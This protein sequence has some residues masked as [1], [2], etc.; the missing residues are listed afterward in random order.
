VRS[1]DLRATPGPRAE[2]AAPTDTLPE[3]MHGF[4]CDPPGLAF[5]PHRKLV[6]INACGRRMDDNP[7]GQGSAWSSRMSAVH[8]SRLCPG[9]FVTPLSAGACSYCGF[10]VAEPRPPSAIGLGA[11]VRGQYIVGRVL[12]KP[13]GFGITYLAFDQRLGQRVALKEYLPRDLAMRAAD[14]ATILPQSQEEGDLFRY[15]LAQFMNEA[16]TL[17]RL[18]HPNIV[19]VRDF[20]EANGTAY[21]AMNYYR[22]LSL[23]EYL[24][25]QRDGRIPE[26]IALA[27]M[28]PVLDG[29]RSVHG[30][31]FLHR[32]IKPANIY[33]AKIDGGGISPIL[34]DFGASRTAIGERSRSLSVV[35]SD[36]YAPFEQYHRRGRQGPATDIYAAGAVL[37]RMLAGDAPPPAPE[38]MSQDTLFPAERFGASPPVSDAIHQ[39]LAVD[40]AERPQT[41]QAFQQSLARAA[42][43]A[44]PRGPAPPAGMESAAEAGHA[45]QPDYAADGG[46]QRSQA[47]FP[48]LLRGD[49]GLPKTFWLYGMLVFLGFGAVL[50][51]VDSLPTLLLVDIL[52]SAYRIAAFIGIWR[53]AVRFAGPKVWSVLAQIV[54]ILLAAASVWNWLIV[55]TLLNDL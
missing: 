53:A 22:G 38:R 32:D 34:I 54:V 48:R 1:T 4:G 20:L 29:L 51:A 15:G 31:G 36:G 45:P 9:C 7:D 3:A 47:F 35:V 52:F 24:A 23:A 27:L 28:Q 17:A 14:G 25:T 55:L 19:R 5:P 16:R 26:R 43:A 40:S 33:L 44:R 50:N 46:R 2:L 49:Y 11:L 18:D 41:V 37:Y 30:Q 10:D 12:G 6:S 21:L 42:P 8:P 13:G 39:A